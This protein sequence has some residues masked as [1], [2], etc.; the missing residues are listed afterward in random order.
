MKTNYLKKYI[1]SSYIFVWMLIIIAP[2][3]NLSGQ[4]R[5]ILALTF[6]KHLS[7]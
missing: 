1:I 3:L 4:H 2:L 6:S 7:R 5:I